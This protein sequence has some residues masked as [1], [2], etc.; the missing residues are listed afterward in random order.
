[1][2]SVSLHSS[3]FS[4]RSKRLSALDS[5]LRCLGRIVVWETL[6][7]EKDGFIGDCTNPFSGL[8][9]GSA[10]RPVSAVG[11]PRESR[12]FGWWPPRAVAEEITGQDKATPERSGV[13]SVVIALALRFLTMEVEELAASLMHAPREPDLNRAFFFG[14]SFSSTEPDTK[15]AAAISTG[16]VSRDVEMMM[17]L[18]KAFARS[19]FGEEGDDKF[20]R[21]RGGTLL[22]PDDYQYRELFN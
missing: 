11:L 9:G 21:A 10:C 4:K 15:E 22:G 5:P 14:C 6:R 16:V 18:D 2:I 3:R 7:I 19:S 20:L 12:S 13:A 1:M 8:R 17:R